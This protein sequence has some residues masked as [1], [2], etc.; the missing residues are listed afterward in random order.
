M[1]LY[2]TYW[3]PSFARAKATGLFYLGAPI[4][5]ILGVAAVQVARKA[6][7][8]LERTL[9]RAGGAG[10]ARAGRLLGWLGIY[11]AL[12]GT[13]SLTVYAVEYYLL[14]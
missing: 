11:L 4:A 13:I 12:I 14:S 9:G 6:R 2:L 1:I 5:F 3:Y 7:R 8:R 10:A